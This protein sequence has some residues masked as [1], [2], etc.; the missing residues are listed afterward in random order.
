[1]DVHINLHCGGNEFQAVG[2]LVARVGSEPGGDECVILEDQIAGIKITFNLAQ[3]PFAARDFL[4]LINAMQ[5]AATTILH[6]D[7]HQ[8]G[9]R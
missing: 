3:H 6:G 1:M 5:G 4:M 8:F 2:H 9:E 7:S